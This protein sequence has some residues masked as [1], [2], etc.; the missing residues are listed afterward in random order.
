MSCQNLKPE[1]MEEYR[2]LACS[3]VH[4]Q[5]AFLCI[6]CLWV[7]HPQGARLCHVNHQSKQ[8]LLDTATDQSDQDGFLIES[9]YFQVTQGH[10]ELTI[11]LNRP[12]SESLR[13]KIQ[14]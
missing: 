11:K 8:P 2:L 6:P 12:V 7:S 5:Q 14:A 3:L 9:L 13:V 1:I 10:F 4:V